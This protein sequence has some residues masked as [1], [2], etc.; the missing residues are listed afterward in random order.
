MAAIFNCGQYFYSGFHLISYHLVEYSAVTCT[1][2]HNGHNSHNLCLQKF[3]ALL[4]IY[5]MLFDV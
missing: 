5:N 2:T 3:L 4:Y 1:F